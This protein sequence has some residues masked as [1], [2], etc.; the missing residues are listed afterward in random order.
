MRRAVTVVAAVAFAFLGPRLTTPQD[1][2]AAEPFAFEPPAGFVDAKDDPGSLEPNVERAWVH[3][4]AGIGFAP[5]IFLTRSKQGGTVESSDLTRL[6]QG[7]PAM[8]EQHGLSWTD[9]R[10]ET[11]TR[12]DGAHVGLIEGDCE[13]KLELSGGA[14]GLLRY[15]RLHLVFPVNGGG[16]VIVTALY[17]KEDASKWAPILEATIGTTKGVAVRLPSPPAWLLGAWAGAGALV[18]WLVAAMM[19]KKARPERR[20]A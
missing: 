1:R 2:S 16:T 12:A 9:V 4:V 20:E 5:R 19:T 17:P 13:K 6:A 14:P 8:L 7:M 10:H 15:R 11:R 18:G 3:P